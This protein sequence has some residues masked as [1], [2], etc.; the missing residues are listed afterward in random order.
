MNIIDIVILL[1]CIPALVQ[2]ERKGF[3]S[4]AVSLV[5]LI[6]GAWL[7]FKFSEPVGNWLGSY[8]EFPGA[9]IHVVAFALIL[10]AATVM[11]NI[12]GKSLEKFVKFIMLGWLDKILGAAFALLK[13]ILLLGLVIILLD[14]VE[15]ILPI[16]P[17]KTFEESMLYEPVKGIANAVFPYLKELIFSK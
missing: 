5:S 9:V 13:V 7:A 6:L 4:Q 11:L 16:I 17:S 3:V 2:G 8:L 10:I 1:C 12:I 14:T 15:S